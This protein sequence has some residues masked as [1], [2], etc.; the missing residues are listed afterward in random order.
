MIDTDYKFGEVHDFASQVGY[1]DG[2]VNFKGIFGN[3]NTIR[4]GEFM[5][6]GAGVPHSVAANVDSKVMLVKVKP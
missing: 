3:A 4:A 5:L 1:G 2:H 6:M